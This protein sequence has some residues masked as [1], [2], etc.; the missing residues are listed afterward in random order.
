[1]AERTEIFGISREFCVSKLLKI[2]LK[3]E[4][5][6]RVG[7]RR[8]RRTLSNDLKALGRVEGAGEK[9]GS[10]ADF[11]PKMANNQMLICFYKTLPCL[12]QRGE[13]YI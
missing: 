10:V 7:R 9:L 4:Q 8:G 12:S 1:M 2:S 11:P 5:V 3:R 13:P 6:W